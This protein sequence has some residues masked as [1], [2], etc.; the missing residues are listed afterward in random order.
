MW[1]ASSKVYAEAY[2][3]NSFKELEEAT[4]CMRRVAIVVVVHRQ[5]HHL[6][7]PDANKIQSLE[8]VCDASY[9]T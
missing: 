3:L 1:K 5:F 9:S 7:K 2:R 4:P 8:V 6:I